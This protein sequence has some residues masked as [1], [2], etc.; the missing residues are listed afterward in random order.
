MNEMIYPMIPVGQSGFP[1]GRV[2]YWVVP[3]SVLTCYT[4]HNYDG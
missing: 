4:S 1:Y 2:L 3:V